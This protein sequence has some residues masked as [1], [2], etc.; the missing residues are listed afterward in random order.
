MIA[1]APAGAEDE[2]FL[3][4]V[5]VGARIG[6]FEALGW[7]E[8]QVRALLHMQYEAQRVSYRRHYPTLLHEKVLEDGVPIGR[9]MTFEGEDELRIVD[10]ALL[11]AYR[12]RGIGRGLI[13]RVQKQAASSGKPLR[14]RVATDN[15]ARRLYERLHFRIYEEIPPYVAMEWQGTGVRSETE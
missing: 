3:F 5:Y 11:P 15:P 13:E 10:L 12:G 14:L 2:P 7:T 9:M 6:D 1:T 4:E 8:T